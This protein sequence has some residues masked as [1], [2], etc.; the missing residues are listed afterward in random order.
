ML[1]NIRKIEISSKFFFI[2]FAWISNAASIT[3]N[4]IKTKKLESLAI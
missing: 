3:I 4:I 2:S 1:V